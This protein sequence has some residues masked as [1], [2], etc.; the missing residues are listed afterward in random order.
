MCQKLISLPM[1]KAASAD[2]DTGMETDLI[3][4]FNH[5]VPHLPK[6]SLH[7]VDSIGLIAMRKEMCSLFQSRFEG[8]IKAI[9]KACLTLFLKF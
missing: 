6:L 7:S 9:C 8:C 4:V 5:D 3:D 2:Y 1:Q